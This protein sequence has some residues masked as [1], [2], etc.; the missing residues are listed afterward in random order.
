MRMRRLH[1][2][3]KGFTL[4]ELLVVLLIVGILA[5]V[6]VPFLGGFIRRA[7]EDTRAAEKGVVQAAASKAVVAGHGTMVVVGVPGVIYVRILADPGGVAAGRAN[8]VG[9]YLPENT[10]YTYTITPEGIVSQ[11]DKWE[12]GGPVHDPLP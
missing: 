9:S 10:I 8:E 7:D 3:E 4:I 11:G 12:V 6:A 2:G 1:K 5:A